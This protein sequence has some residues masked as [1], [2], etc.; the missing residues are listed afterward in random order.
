[1]PVPSHSYSTCDALSSLCT[2][3]DRVSSFKTRS[4]L[5]GCQFFCSE[6]I[7]IE[8]LPAVTSPLFA[9][10]RLR[11]TSRP[12]QDVEVVL[13]VF[14]SIVLSYETFTACTQDGEIKFSLTSTIPL[15]KHPNVTTEYGVGL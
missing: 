1:M 10:L 14:W 2:S 3:E 6:L 11:N 7:S 13:S 9:S 5:S 4:Q 15:S 8:Q 12:E